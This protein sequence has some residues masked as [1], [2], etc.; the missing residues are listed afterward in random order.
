MVFDGVTIYQLL[1]LLNTFAGNKNSLAVEYTNS[2]A[3][4][5]QLGDSSA[6]HQNL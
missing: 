5:D 2:G 3:L 1:M 6:C 4:E